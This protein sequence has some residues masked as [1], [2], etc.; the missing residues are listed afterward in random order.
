MLG[1]IVRLRRLTSP[2]RVGYD[3]PVVSVACLKRAVLSASSLRAPFEVLLVV[4]AF[5]TY[6]V[7]VVY[8]VHV[9][10]SYIRFF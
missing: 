7:P 6:Q 2:L 4:W 3:R 8:K 9:A 1:G 5:D 10:S